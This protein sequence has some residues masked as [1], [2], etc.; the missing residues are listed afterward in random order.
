MGIRPYRCEIA[1]IPMKTSEIQRT[2]TMM[3]TIRLLHSQ[4]S[5]HAVMNMKKLMKKKNKQVNDT[6]CPIT[7]ICSDIGCGLLV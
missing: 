4:S 1:Q 3:M 7:I 5:L 2:S 6:N